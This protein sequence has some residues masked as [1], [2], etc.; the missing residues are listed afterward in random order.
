MRL[1]VVCPLLSGMALLQRNSS[2]HRA[3][4]S[5]SVTHR[6]SLFRNGSFVA[7]GGDSSA[8][9]RLLASSTTK[10]IVS[11]TTG[12]NDKSISYKDIAGSR[13]SLKS[14]G[15]LTFKETSGYVRRVVFVLGGPGSGK[16]S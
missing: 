1:P 6:L 3:C 14:F 12:D 13:K 2:L 9:S 15:G 4:D 10:E 8:P 7:R 5:T 11:K 16:V